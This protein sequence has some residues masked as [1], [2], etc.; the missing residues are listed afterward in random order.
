VASS[1]YIRALLRGTTLR[2]LTEAGTADDN[3]IGLKDEITGSKSRERNRYDV[4]IQPGLNKT[5]VFLFVNV[6]K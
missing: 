4:T 6:I 2:P 3:K 1:I 5:N